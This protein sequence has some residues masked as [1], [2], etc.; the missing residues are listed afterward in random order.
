MQVSVRV[1]AKINL[2]LRVGPLRDDGFHEL[3][4]VFHGVSLYDEVTVSDEVGSD[5]PSDQPPDHLS[6][7]FTDEGGDGPLLTIGGPHG[8]GLAADA[9]NLAIRAIDALA[10][11]AGRTPRARLHIHKGI[12]VSAGLAGGSAD[13]AGTLLACNQLWGLDWPVA[14]LLPIAQKLGSDVPFALVGGTAVGVGRGE[15]LDPVPVGR[16]LHWVV[17]AADEGLSTPDVYRQLDALRAAREMESADPA[18]DASLLT[19]LERGDVRTIGG[20]LA[21]DLQ[22]AALELRPVLAD[23]LRAGNAAGALGGIVSG[24]GPTCVFL[25]ES[26]AHARD[27]AAALVAAGACAS[28]EPV[29]GPAVP[30]F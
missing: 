11:A 7:R 21:N 19:A 2:A 5:Q 22:E 26:A 1:P 25:V 27:V 18:V 6:R 14:R 30:S 17:A 3:T 29:T 23:T 8:S 12:P 15:Q 4:T 13:A 20:L 16:D 24:S 28:A 10:K 9:S